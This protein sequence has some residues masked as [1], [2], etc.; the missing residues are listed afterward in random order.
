[1]KRAKGYVLYQGPS[2]LNG[3]SIVAIATMRT[4]NLKTGNMVQTWI[5]TADLNPVEALKRGAD[6]AV[7]GTCP[8]RHNLGGGCYVIPFQAPNRVWAAWKRGL[9]PEDWQPEVFSGKRIRLGSYGD[10]AAVPHGVWDRVLRLAGG[11]TGYTHQAHRREFQPTLLK[12]VMVSADSSRAASKFHAEGL[13]TFRVKA[14]SEALLPGE[15]LCPTEVDEY[16]ECSTCG[17]CSGAEKPGPSVAINAHGRRAHKVPA[18]QRLA[19]KQLSLRLIPLQQL[20]PA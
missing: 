10:P 19:A 14:P 18:V 20:E 17:I 3:E 16:A 1:M 4:N 8:H 13:R 6:E 12:H 5:L 7:C 15:I 2:L 11:S 9:Y